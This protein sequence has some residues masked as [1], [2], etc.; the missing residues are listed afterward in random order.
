MAGENLHGRLVR[1]IKTRVL[2]WEYPPGYRLMENE[3]CKEYEV[4]RSPAREALRTLEADGFLEKTPQRGYVV[5]QPDPRKVREMYEVR[6]ALELFV[7]EK[8]A[9]GAVSTE[10]SRFG[11][12]QS[13]WKDSPNC[14]D[15]ETEEFAE[16]DR[17]FH[18]I[19]A[20][21]LGNTS[22]IRHLAMIDDRIQVFRTIE[23][24]DRQTREMTC[25]QHMDILEAIL[26]GDV[27]ATK[28]AIKINIDTALQN[29]EEVIKEALVRSHKFSG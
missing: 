17:N 27:T 13:F 3:V 28:R 4:S 24:A 6:L 5:R 22:L 15:R 2:Q 9:G 29:V 1:A 21:M 8:L 23:F 11:E 19:L 7:G 18:E 26:K 14:A 12:L 25:N 10:D 16:R 20:S